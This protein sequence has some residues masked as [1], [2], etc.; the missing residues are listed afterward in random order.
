MHSAVLAGA[1]A[2][3][4]VTLFLGLAAA[5]NAHPALVARSGNRTPRPDIGTSAT[6]VSLFT[7]TLS[8][9]WLWPLDRRWPW[10]TLLEKSSE[11]EKRTL[12]VEQRWL[13]WCIVMSE[14][15]AVEMDS[16]HSSPPYWQAA[17]QRNKRYAQCHGYGFA[18][19]QHTS[20]PP[21]RGNGCLHVRR[22]ALSPYWCKIP[23]VA[24]VLRHGIDGH[25]CEK[26]VFLDSDVILLNNSIGLDDYL[27][28]ARFLGDEALADDRWQLLFTSN[29]PHVPAG[30]CTGIFFIRN[31]VD[32]CGILRN[33]WDADWPDEGEKWSWGQG[34]MAEGVHAYNRAYGDRVRLLPTS[35]AWRIEDIPKLAR[36]LARTPH[37]PLLQAAHDVLF[38]HRCQAVTGARRSDDAGNCRPTAPAEAAPFQQCASTAPVSVI[39]L[40]NA[41]MVFE[42]AA[43]CPAAVPRPGV[44]RNTF[45]SASACCHGEPLRPSWTHLDGMHAT[46]PR[47]CWHQSKKAANEV[48]TCWSAPRAPLRL[49]LPPPHRHGVH[50]WRSLRGES[51]SAA[52]SILYS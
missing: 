34:A 14:T 16:M 12:A 21:P 33:W 7:C 6:I 19:V 46:Q 48:Y 5:C 17:A 50:A 20:T 10:M 32:S 37:S 18:Y 8:L 27:S 38:H 22:G 51:H 43:H 3:V 39:R 1:G 23:A 4:R 49:P 28:R 40:D 30:L 36:K 47:P 9:A 15:R 26:A 13:P 44:S 2:A 42:D 31:T 24:H 29:A 35:H 41:G 25:R 45:M 52:S 11:V